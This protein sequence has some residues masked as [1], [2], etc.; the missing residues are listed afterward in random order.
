VL[1][2]TTIPGVNDLGAQVIRAEIGGDMTRFPSEAH[3]ISWVG[4]CPQNDE[5]A[6]K[7]RSNRM[8]LTHADGSFLTL[9]WGRQSAANLSRKWSSESRGFGGPTAKWTLSPRLAYLSDCY[10]AYFSNA[11]IAAAADFAVYQTLSPGGRPI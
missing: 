8:R 2:L 11:G 9:R 7:R 6:G 1:L 3:L 10:Y 4:L 5:S